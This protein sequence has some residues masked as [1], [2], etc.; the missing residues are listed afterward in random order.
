[1]VQ[2]ANVG[3]REKTKH[4]REEVVQHMSADVVMD[5]VEDAV[6]PVNGGQATPQVAPLLHKPCTHES[7]ETTPD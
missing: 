6:V 3:L 5:L 4:L 7:A 1:M 2:Q